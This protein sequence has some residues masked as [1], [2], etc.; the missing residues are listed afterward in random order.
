MPL[1][2]NRPVPNTTSDLPTGLVTFVFTDIE[3]STRLLKRNPDQ[4]AVLFRRHD[5]LLREQWAAHG[6][7]EVNTEGDSFFVAFSDPMDALGA[8]ASVQRALADEPWPGGVTIAVRIGAHIGLAAPHNGDYIALAVHQ[9]NRVM[10]A[11]RG[12]QIIVSDAVAKSVGGLHP[13]GRLTPLGVFRLRD[14]DGPE[15]VF[16]FDPNGLTVNTEPLRAT[17]AGGHNIVRTPTSF[18]GRDSDLSAVCELVNR[19]RVSGARIVT[20]AGPGGVGKTRLAME[21]GFAVVHDW[22]DGVWMVDL[23]DV[24]D[25]D[26]VADA[27]AT[28]LG[29]PAVGADCLEH[30]INHLR[31][32]TALIVLDNIELHLDVCARLARELVTRCRHVG[33]L[34]TGQEPLNIGG[35][36]VYRLATLPTPGA[37]GDTLEPE[38]MA[39]CPSVALFVDRVRDAMPSFAL[40]HRT[41]GDV[42]WICNRLDGLPLAVEI[43]AARVRVLSLPEIVVGLD[44]RFTLLKS[45][46]R[47]LPERQRTMRGLMDWSVRLLDDRERVALRRLSVFAGSFPLYASEVAVTD[48]SIDKDDVAELVWSLVDKSLVVADL[49][50]SSTRYR[51][52][53]T[54][55]AYVRQVLAES[56]QDDRAPT[57]LVEWYLDLLG[58]WRSSDRAWVGNVGI[59]LA[60]LRGLI[61]L[62]HPAAPELA[63]QLA[64]VIARYHDSVQSISAGIEELTGHVDRL[65]EPT[66]TRVVMLTALADLHLRRAQSE[67]ASHLLAE[68]KELRERV[69]VADWNDAAVDRTSG[70]IALR[71]GDFDSAIAIVDAALARG[72]SL[73]G[74]A[75]MSNLAGIAYYNTGDL[76]SASVA[77]QRELDLWTEL[78]EEAIVASALGNI[79]E[80]AMQRFDN[81]SA[82]RYQR[83]CLELG[84]ALGQPVMI[85]YSCTVAARLAGRL[86]NWERATQLQSAA[87]AALA[88]I[89]MTLY[90]ADRAAVDEMLLAAASALGP[91]LFEEECSFG[92][93]LDVLDAARLADEVLAVV[94]DDRPLST[95]ATSSAASSAASSANFVTDTKG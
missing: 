55:R 41:A 74:Q 33:V 52:P 19:G 72:L 57:R 76:D 29:A 42:A 95:V 3:G 18:V 2:E 83:A 85:S 43:A 91:A 46:D 88:T 22:P 77:F 70:E 53:E 39:E 1:W 25:S 11:G 20:I 92:A 47:M 12:G 6:G 30:V 64:V 51:L 38:P 36:T 16:R 60:N 75:R 23:A 73:R 81:R 26:L 93:R 68:A 82:A 40:D 7:H 45:R 62:V 80:V 8:C 32:R 90:E 66:A 79:A 49:S 5:E 13:A 86:G 27:V 31:E 65:D 21:V 94:A 15:P 69:G 48:D 89:G 34:T 35:E 59:E 50:D 44:D 58:P 17:P 78:G 87:D 71:S 14:F 28:E 61:D 54:V 63:Q 84:Q 67:P 10:A 56:A 4:A 9:A 37:F 24:S